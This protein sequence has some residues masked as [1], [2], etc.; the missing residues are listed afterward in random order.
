MK[1]STLFS[2]TTILVLTLSILTTNQKA[3]AQDCL[4]LKFMESKIEF[5]HP[6]DSTAAIQEEID[7]FTSFGLS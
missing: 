4:E 5:E 1:K 6:S 2:L 7:F 3:N